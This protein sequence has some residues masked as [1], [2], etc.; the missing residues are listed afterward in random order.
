MSKNKVKKKP[1]CIG[2]IFRLFIILVL[3][4]AVFGAFG[5]KKETKDAPVQTINQK[6]DSLVETPD[7]NTPIP[8]HTSTPSSVPTSTPTAEPTEKPT[9][10]PT[11]K[12]TSEPTNTPEKESSEINLEYPDLGEY[13]TYY[14]FNE[15]V[16]KAEESDKETIIQCFVPAG[17]YALTNNGKYPTFVYIYSKDTVIS[18]DGWEEPAE[19]WSSKMLNVGDTCDITIEEGHYINLQENDVFTLIIK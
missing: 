14:T 17:E 2:R 10:E 1:G 18:E 8:E 15:K 4:G 12:P 13:G 19:T 6:T 5:D 7:A 3:I 11:E 9:A 16:K